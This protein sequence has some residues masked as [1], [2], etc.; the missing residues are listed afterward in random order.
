M[1]TIGEILKEIRDELFK[2]NISESQIESEIIIE[3]VLGISTEKLY[4]NINKQCSE[5]E[6]KNIIKVLKKRKQRIPLPYI[7]ENCYFY[8][9]KF[10]IY[11]GILIP[12][13]ETELLIDRCL[14]N[15]PKSSN[16]KLS[17]LDI[18][19]GSGIIAI[20]L[21]LMS[22]LLTV[23]AL[24]ISKEAINLTKK[25]IELHNLN[26][27][28]NLFNEDFRDH[29]SMKYDFI[30]ANLPYIPKNRF[31]SLPPELKFEPRLALD[32]GENGVELITDLIKLLPKIVKGTDSKVILE[33]D[34]T[35]LKYVK[36]IIN[37]YLKSAK[38]LSLKDL[39]GKDRIVEIS[40]IK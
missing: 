36:N 29:L 30:L 27:K 32:G 11:S 1:P 15:I 23:N 26:G 37:I 14:Y 7:T 31:P 24:D 18:G 4:S 33:I 16:I 21:K 20:I 13:P 12:R 19:T 25:N 28:I 17:V 5:K 10:H 34:S 40:N 3:N 9:K 6:Y 39:S 8:G 22:P 38:I 2:K 35:Q